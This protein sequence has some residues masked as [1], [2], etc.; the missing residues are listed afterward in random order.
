MRNRSGLVGA[1]LV[2]TAIFLAVAAGLISPHSPT[3]QFEKYPGVAP[4]FQFILGTDIFGRDLL[5]RIIFGARVSLT[6]G[7]VAEII[8]LLIG[9]TIGAVAGYY[10]GWI[11]NV[12]M[13]ITDTFYSFPSLLLAIAIL[14]IFSEPGRG[15][16]PNIALVF[17]ALGLAGWTGVA[18]VIRGQVLALKE[19]EFVEGARAI[20][21]SDLRILLKHILPNCVAPIIVLGT[22]GV[23]DN[24]LSE[25]GLSFLGLG[26]QPPTPSWG[27]MIFEGRAF[28]STKPWLGIF[29]GLAIG[30]T[31]L[32]F[33]L[34]GDGLRDLLDPRMKR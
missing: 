21:A 17:I 29:P 28:F 25:A 31:V 13:R 4:G 22:I 8:A 24:V 5:S 23:A 3:A 19:M 9:I 6:V 14:A 2:M 33:N 20:G 7:V 1:I 15:G 11:D 18:R 30:L 16:L 27:Y 34:F 32:G 10:R 12:L 26:I